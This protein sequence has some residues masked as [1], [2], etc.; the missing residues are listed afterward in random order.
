MVSEDHLSGI[1]RRTHDARMNVLF[2]ANWTKRTPV[3]F[4]VDDRGRV[5]TTRGDGTF[6]FMFLHTSATPVLRT[7]CDDGIVDGR[8]E[9]KHESVSQ[10]EN[11][12][13]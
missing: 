7:K 3:G 5:T 8:T 4:I 9:Q 6:L 10:M 1:G 12:Y 13:F 11:I 2:L